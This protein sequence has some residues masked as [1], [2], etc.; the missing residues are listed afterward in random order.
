MDNSYKFAGG[1]F[2]STVDDL[3]KIGNTMIYCHA[4]NGEQYNPKGIFNLDFQPKEHLCSI[5]E[6]VQPCEGD[7]KQL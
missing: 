7:P 4:S 5:E 6:G 2:M 3:L 1:G